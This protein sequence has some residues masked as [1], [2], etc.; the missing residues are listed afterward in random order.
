MFLEEVIA[1]GQ[2]E[3]CLFG[4]TFSLVWEADGLSVALIVGDFGELDEVF[5]LFGGV[6]GELAEVDVGEWFAGVQ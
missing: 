2:A 5:W 1:G 6:K 4:G 3:D